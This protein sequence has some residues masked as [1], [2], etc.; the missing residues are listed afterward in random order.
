[1]TATIIPGPAGPAPALP[2]QEFAHLAQRVRD[3][4]LMGKRPGYYSV[5]I[6]IT[7][8]ALIALATLGVVLASSWWIIAVA[9]GM[10]FTLAQL[11][12]IAHD[13]GHRQVSRDRR[14]NHL[15]GLLISNLC[16]GV[17][18][19][20]WLDKHNRHHAHT[21]QPGRDPDLEPGALAY[22]RDQVEARR[23]LPRWFARIQVFLLVPL[24]FLEA[25]NL[26]VASIIDLIRRHD[27]STIGEAA[28][29]AVHGALFFVAPFLLMGVWQA[30]AF[31]VVTQTAFGFY[32]GA[33][34]L[35]NH[36][37]MPVQATTDG[38]DYMRRQ[39]LTSRNLRGRLVTGFMVGGLDA[40]I[41]HH[42]FP[43][44]PRANLR[45]ARALVRSFCAD[46]SIDYTEASAWRAYRD[47]FAYLKATGASLRIPTT[48]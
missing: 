38:L 15:I 30:V 4:G 27:R 6:S 10:A 9:L 28:L 14:W 43:T 1:M 33:S 21:N 40:Q 12:F 20:W 8:A 29:M 39:V 24:L 47:V 23:G 34:F 7:A 2:R 41:E 18:F 22:T 17:S 26:H 37:G 25:V 19:S 31:V 11:S 16:A 36:V 42:L 3:A 48:V 5:K 46:E 35:T 32:L 44:M 45:R 13:A